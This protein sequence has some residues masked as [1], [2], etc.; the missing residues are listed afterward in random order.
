MNKKTL[1]ILA[2][3]FVGL[4]VVASYPEWKESVGFTQSPVPMS[5]LSFSPFTQ[6]TTEQVVI[7]KQGEEE[8]TLLKKNGTWVMNNLEASE[9]SVDDFFE[10]LTALKVGSLAS[11]NKENFSGFGVDDTGYTLSLSRNGEVTTFIVGS[12]GPSLGSFYVRTKDGANVY[13]IEGKLPGTLAQSV[14]FW[15]E[16]T[17]VKVPTETI[18]KIEIVSKT[19]PLLITRTEDGKWQAE[20]VGKKAVLDETTTK[21]MLES[22]DSL[23]GSDFL[24]P[25]QEAEFKKTG[26]K[27][28]LRLFDGMNK[29]LAEIRFLKK[30]SDWWATVEGQELFYAVP[31]YE[32]SDILLTQEQAFGGDKK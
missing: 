24:T 26:G 31:A 2:G 25:E 3:I 13:L 16:K 8:K 30:N 14:S 11:K 19:D 12:T 27:T 29:K 17:L 10:A 5:E 21:N 23:E 4:I 20:N 18:Q 9:K 7:S 6:E 1:L 22:F 15:R 28:I 32:L